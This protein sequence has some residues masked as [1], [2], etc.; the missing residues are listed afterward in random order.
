[1]K[2]VFTLLLSVVL[3]GVAVADGTVADKAPESA[4]ELGRRA[5]AVKRASRLERLSLYRSYKAAKHQRKAGE[6]KAINAVNAKAIDAAEA[7]AEG[8]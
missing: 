4:V 7:K 3:A 2:S 1:M 5:H 8:K 6:L